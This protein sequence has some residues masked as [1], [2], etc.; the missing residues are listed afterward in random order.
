MC[1]PITRQ[2]KSSVRRRRR[3]AADRRSTGAAP[4]PQYLARSWSPWDAGCC[5]PHGSIQSPCASPVTAGHRWSSHASRLY[6]ASLGSRQ[7]ESSSSLLFHCTDTAA[8]VAAA[9]G[10]NRLT[11]I[12]GSLPRMVQ[13]KVRPHM[14]TPPSFLP[15]A[16]GAEEEAG[17]A[18]SRVL[19][20]QAAAV[21]LFQKEAG[22]IFSL[23]QR[24]L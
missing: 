12:L 16:V 1:G 4:T 2:F 19:V 15:G 13:P 7:L 6:C 14:K 9:A 21:R 5:A 22:R 18:T 8:A 20:S 10:I 24:S 3:T 17:L 11:T 23:I